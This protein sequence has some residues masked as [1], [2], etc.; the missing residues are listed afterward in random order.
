MVSPPASA[1][2]GRS[3]RARTRFRSGPWP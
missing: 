2:T 1:P 3:A